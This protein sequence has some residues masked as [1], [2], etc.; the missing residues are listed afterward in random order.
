MRQS[1]S[2]WPLERYQSLD[3]GVYIA[4][5]GGVYPHDGVEKRDD[6]QFVPI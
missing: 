6:G 1:M 5:S 2:A 3:P 4:M